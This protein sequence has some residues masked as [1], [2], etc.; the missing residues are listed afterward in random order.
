MLRLQNIHFCPLC[1]ELSWCIII[2]IIIIICSRVLCQGQTRKAAAHVSFLHD[3]MKKPYTRL[4]DTLQ[5]NLHTLI[6]NLLALDTETLPLLSTINGPLHHHITQTHTL[7]WWNRVTTK[8]TWAHFK[9]CVY[10]KP[11]TT[12]PSIS[13]ISA[14]FCHSKLAPQLL[15]DASLFFS[16]KSWVLYSTLQGAS[17]PFLWFEVFKCE[18]CE[19]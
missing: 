18:M 5:K 12:I 10:Y 15:L 8:Q 6:D 17:V 2:I 16:T 9:I 11:C 13:S 14:D 7:L 19:H 1:I 3:M 4:Q